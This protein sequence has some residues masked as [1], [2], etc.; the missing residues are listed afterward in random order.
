MSGD[1]GALGAEAG[2][3]IGHGDTA[4]LAA[5]EDPTVSTDGRQGRRSLWWPFSLGAVLLLAL[6]LRIWNIAH[7]LPAVYNPDEAGHFVRHAVQFLESG[8]LQLDYFV[9]PPALTHL[10]AGA[11]G[12]IFGGGSG[13]ARAFSE[14][15]GSVYLVA[16]V[17]VALLGVVSVWVLYFVGR[18]LF[19][20]RWVACARR[21]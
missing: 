10:L 16:R 18:A 20:R 9:N 8:T 4:L 11:F 21:P 1:N 15:P 13:V 7:G 17:V 3:G 2:M 14:N 12:A 5:V 19:D 6:V